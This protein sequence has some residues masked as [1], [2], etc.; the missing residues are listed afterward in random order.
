MGTQTEATRKK[1][2]PPPVSAGLVFELEKLAIPG[3][4]LLFEACQK[5]LKD[6]HVAL[7]PV[8]WSRFGLA[9]PLAQGL[10]RLIATLD[11]KSLAADKLAREI[12]DIFFREIARPAVKL[13]ATLNALLTEVAK[14]NIKIGALSFLPD[15]QAQA[16]LVHLGLQERVRLRV[17]QKEA[18]V[19]VPT[20][21]CW[22]MTCKAIGVPARRCVAV[23]EN[24]VACN[25]ALEAGLRCVVAPDELTAYQD[26][27]GADQVVEDL[28]D[29]HAKDLQ[30]LLHSCA[31]R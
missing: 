3:Q 30:A 26:F 4:R 1:T 29:L 15:E 9:T 2:A 10:D 24:A 13:N 20:P 22:L 18:A 6:K 31:F 14:F 28:K 27:G 23:V 7:T 5:V 25:A 8:L 19:S 21:D 12:Q 17:M 16:L 11:K